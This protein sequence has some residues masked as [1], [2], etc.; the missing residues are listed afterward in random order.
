MYFFTGDDGYFLY[1][2]PR[3]PQRGINPQSVARHLNIA[4]GSAVFLVERSSYMCN[5]RLGEFRRAHMRGD[6]YRYRIDL[7]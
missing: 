2:C 3:L 4:V 5:D 6:L 1:F 7:R